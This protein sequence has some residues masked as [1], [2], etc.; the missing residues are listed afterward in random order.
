MDR[1]KDIRLDQSQSS[2][3]PRFRTLRHNSC[4]VR[5]LGHDPHHAKAACCRKLL[6]MNSNFPDGLLGRGLDT[7]SQIPDEHSL[8]KK[9]L[10]E[11][12]DT[13][14][15]LRI[16]DSIGGPWKRATLYIYTCV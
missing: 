11:K 4:R 2:P 12:T 8:V 14:L 1:R 16:P 6:V 15:T 10:A 13:L 9:G 7:P 5:L 3:S